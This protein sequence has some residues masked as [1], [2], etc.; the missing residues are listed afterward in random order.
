MAGPE[1]KSRRLSDEQK[2]RVAHHEVGYALVA[3]YSIRTD[4]V[5]KIS[6]IPRGR[7][8][9]G[10]TLQLPTEVHFLRSRAD[11]LE[12][13]RVMLAGRAA[14]ELVFGG[15]TTGAQNDLEHATALSIRSRSSGPCKK[16]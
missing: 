9:L 14:E 15:V 11:L 5:H 13:I 10:Y 1:S 4:P 8:A 6:I 7:S 12:R 3:A 2:R 16:A